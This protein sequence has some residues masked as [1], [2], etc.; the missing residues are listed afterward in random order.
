MTAWLTDRQ[1]NPGPPLQRATLW[2]LAAQAG[3]LVTKDRLI[4]ALWGAAAP[5]TAEQSLYTY[6]AGLRRLLEPERGRR[7]PFTLLTQSANGYSLARDACR[8]DAEDFEQRLAEA[9]RFQ[10][11][12]DLPAW[13]RELEAGLGLWAGP[14][15][16]GLPGPF[17]EAERARLESMRLTAREDY[18][19]ALLRLGR[20][21]ESLDALT[22]LTAEA[23][24]RERPRELLMLALYRCG[25]Q[26]EALE[27]FHDTRR[28]LAE[29]LGVDPG[30]PL[31]RAYELILRA[32]PSLA[33]RTSGESALPPPARAPH[34]LPRDS[35]VFVGRTAMLVRL[36]ALLA[37]WDGGDPQSVV[38]VTGTAG[39]GKSTLA[40]HA[41]HAASDHYPDGCLYV[42]L[43]GATPGV[44]RLSSLTLLGRL[45]RDLGV[46]AEAVP[47][48]PGEAASMLRDRLLGRRMLIVLDDAAGP[49][50]VRPLLGLPAGNALLVTSRES[51]AVADDC[52]QLV[53]GRMLRSEAVTVLAKLVGAERVAADP[54]AAAEL[55]DLC[56]RLPLALRLAAAR[57]TENRHMPLSEL[58]SRLRDQR[59]ALHELES[60]D[61][62][63]RASLQLSHDLLAAG[64][65]QLDRAAAAAL[66]HLGVPHVPDA[67]ADVVAALLDVP[68]DAAER[69]VARLVRANLAEPG[70]HGRFRLHD[71]VRL[72][73][74]ELAERRLSER[75]RD[76]ALDR[77]I[78][79]YGTTARLAMKLIDPHRVH[80]PHEFAGCEQF[81][82]TGSADASAWLVRERANV[83]AVAAQA[84]ASGNSCL[85]RSGAHLIFSFHWPLVFTG[86]NLDI[87][88]L[89]RKALEVGDRLD[90][91]GI[92]AL[93]HGYLAQGLDHSGRYEEA[94][95]HQRAEVALRR[96]IGDPFSRMRALGNLA[97]MLTSLKVHE[98]A[99][100]SAREQL[101]IAREI[102][103]AVGERHAL[104][105]VGSAQ[106]GLGDVAAAVAAYTEMESLAR[107]AGDAMHRADALMAMAEVHL[108]QE[109]HPSVA[110]LYEKA[111]VLMRENRFRGM[112][113]RC[114]GRLGQ[115]ERLMGRFDRA[116]AYLR[117]TL[118]V[119]Q[120]C[121]AGYWVDFA[122][123][124]LALLDGGRAAPDG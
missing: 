121:G 124:E 24:L 14:A 8:T 19:D 70:E 91:Q 31:R 110:E 46:H 2:V 77:V 49:E 33:V 20:H 38:A 78:G 64:P 58:N 6:V 25:R 102:G 103:A 100:S 107:E 80:P 1:V 79:L 104:L 67:T 76:D 96:T 7:G 69:T 18:A 23:P 11:K 42:N 40:V 65:N 106:L 28:L 3:R 85:A 63:V 54:A 82:L 53:L 122:R 47:S 37:P 109:D 55:A 13:L 59:R 84:M 50:Q 118:A 117:E 10:A 16:G 120:G 123:E 62:A 111:L 114:L 41:A 60:G 22:A 97:V 27:V 15:L 87:L 68:R 45:L 105:C 115:A 5:K 94:L 44:T 57:L 36:R 81:A 21:Q 98:E 88:T 83:I 51:F 9:R 71:L 17:C 56:G 93:A 43:L 116:R 113:P 99:L 95:L 12:Q 26:A 48:D 4:D 73:A 119:A 92:S 29:H 72:F 52:V 112:E 101:R 86:H 39:A 89:S 108:V 90:D 32:D 35:R 61:L 75:D 74:M 30:E 66:C 34:Q